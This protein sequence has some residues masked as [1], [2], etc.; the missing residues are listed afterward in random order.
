MG[1]V[2]G[3]V[4]ARRLHKGYDDGGVARSLELAEALVQ[5]SRNVQLIN[6]YRC[7][8]ILSTLCE[9]SQQCSEQTVVLKKVTI[10]HE[11]SFILF[12]ITFPF[13][14]DGDCTL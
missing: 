10:F 12:R 11:G 9:L 4:S 5:I 3:A 8:A 7:A 2:Y 13:L 14:Y 1:L 6:T